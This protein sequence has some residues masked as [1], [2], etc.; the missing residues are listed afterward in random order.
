MEIGDY[1]RYCISIRGFPAGSKFHG[2]IKDATFS[3]MAFRSGKQNHYNF[4]NFDQIQKNAVLF[5][6]FIAQN[7]VWHLW[8]STQ[9]TRLEVLLYC[10][11]VFIFLY[12]YLCFSHLWLSTQLTRLEVLLYCSRNFSALNWIKL[13]SILSENTSSQVQDIDPYTSS[14]EIHSLQIYLIA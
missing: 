9:L 1:F 11:F 13:N 4:R 7:Y 10:I 6:N 8:L 3:S 2:R 14:L 12:F 5:N